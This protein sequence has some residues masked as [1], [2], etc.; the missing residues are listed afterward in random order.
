MNDKTVIKRLK[1]DLTDADITKVRAHERAA[2]A[3]LLELFQYRPTRQGMFMTAVSHAAPPNALATFRSARG[4]E[5]PA[6]EPSRNSQRHHHPW[7]PALQ[8]VGH[9]A[10]T[11]FV[12]T[13]FITLVWL[14][15]LGFSFLHSIHPFPDDVFQLF[16]ALK[17]ALILIDAALSGAVLLR[18]LWQYLLNVVRGGS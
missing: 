12:F 3:N 10:A 2:S 6:Q 7:P 13:S 4:P 1:A 9:M 15:S 8:L 17:R 14:A 5:R 11:A 18:G 16:E